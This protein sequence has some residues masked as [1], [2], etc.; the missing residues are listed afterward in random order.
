[1]SPRDGFEDYE[2]PEPGAVARRLPEIH[3]DLNVGLLADPIRRGQTAS[4]FCTASHP[5]FC[6]GTMAYMETNGA[7]RETLGVLG[8]S[9][10]D[11]KNI[12][13]VVSPD[14][15]IALT[16]I[17]GDKNTGIA[18]RSASTRR[19]RR[20]A[21]V[22]IVLRNAQLT[23][24]FGDEEPADNDEAVNTSQPTWF[25]LYYREGDTIRSEFSLAGAVSEDGRKL[26]WLERLIL[27]EINLLNAPMP[28]GP[29]DEGPDVDVP[30]ER[31]TG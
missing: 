30:V 12:P 24:L 11:D 29:A 20:S 2:I 28:S 1:M 26:E 3:P 22:R 5:V 15:T 7:L 6:T 27:P 25:L 10:K 19:P 14:G 17:S 9:L 4:E 18:N 13:T 16:A 31:R 21:S 23:L 8:W